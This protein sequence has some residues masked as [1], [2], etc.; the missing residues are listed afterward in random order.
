MPAMDKAMGEVLRAS[1]D[2]DWE[3]DD[4]LRGGLHDE[5]APDVAYE[6]VS[7][8]ADAAAQEETMDEGDYKRG[9]RFKRCVDTPKR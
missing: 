6:A 2:P 8:A 9:K 5:P 4:G 3:E 7:I 1:Q